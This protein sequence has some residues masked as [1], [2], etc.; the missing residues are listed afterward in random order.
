MALQGD[1]TDRFG[2]E[3]TQAYAKITFLNIN[4]LN[5]TGDL[6]VNIWHDQTAR[7]NSKEPV[8]MK[9]FMIDTTTF[10]TLLGQAAGISTLFNPIYDWIKTKEFAGWT[11]V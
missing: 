3:H 2:V 11:D 4:M 8:E 7:T 5:F 10:N 6:V 9:H 1:Y